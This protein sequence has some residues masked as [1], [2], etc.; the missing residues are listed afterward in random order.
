MSDYI[1]GLEAAKEVVLQLMLVHLDMEPTD[2]LSEAIDLIDAEIEK[3]T[4][5]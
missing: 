5:A 4:K 1:R 2:L 3:G